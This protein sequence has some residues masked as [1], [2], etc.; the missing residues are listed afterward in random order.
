MQDPYEILG[1]PRDADMDEIK[2][3]YRKLSRKYHPD[4][5]INNPNKDQAEEKFKQVQQAYQKIVDE[6]EH[7]GTSSAS[8]SG[9]GNAGGYGYGNTGSGGYYQQEEESYGYDPFRDFFGYGYGYRQ[10]QQENN[11]GGNPQLRAAANYINN[12]YY[13]EAMN[14]LE[15]IPERNGNWYYLRACANAGLG[16]NVAALDD[17][18]MAV[19]LEPQNQQFRQLLTQLESGR[20]WYGNGGG[21]MYECNS[22]SA[23]RYCLPC[24]ICCGVSRCCMPVGTGVYCC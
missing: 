13:Q 6:K 11:Y 15:R 14:V 20:A 8:Q 9:Y 7:G 24:C 16:N 2:K 5:N 22:T 10:Q 23:I 12:G 4:A 1:V 19:N 3:A 18:R 17:A 21:G